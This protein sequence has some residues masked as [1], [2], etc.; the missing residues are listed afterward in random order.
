[1]PWPFGVMAHDLCD[2]S[3][4]ARAPGLGSKGTRVL[5]WSPRPTRY[6]PSRA[7]PCP[8][9]DLFFGPHTSSSSDSRR[10][11]RPL[12]GQRRGRST[13]PMPT[14]YSRKTNLPSFTTRCRKFMS[15]T[16]GARLWW[17]MRWLS[18]SPK[19]LRSPVR[20][21]PTRARRGKH[22]GRRA[23]ESSHKERSAY[24]T[25]DVPTAQPHRR[26]LEFLALRSGRC[27]AWS[28]KAARAGEAPAGNRELSEVRT[29][30]VVSSQEDLYNCRGFEDSACLSC[31]SRSPGCPWRAVSRSSPIWGRGRRP[32]H[33]ATFGASPPW[34]PPP[35]PCRAR[36]GQAAG[37][38]R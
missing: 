25:R 23:R 12:R 2:H 8:R 36:L 28:R 35:R 29:E 38:G 31:P 3:S 14:P 26:G 33:H 18:G 37:W 32:Q 30:L 20:H 19:T 1:M 16:C 6:G 9:G 4:M 34:S 24:S 11:R 10:H 7:S 17:A 5:V 22:R 27:S 13:R 15:T 21:G